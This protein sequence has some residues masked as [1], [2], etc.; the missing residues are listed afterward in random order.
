MYDWQCV[1]IMS[2]TIY[3]KSLAAGVNLQPPEVRRR[4]MDRAI[5]ESVELYDM[6]RGLD[7]RWPATLRET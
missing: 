1:A 7:L 4:I 6:Q 2:A 5:Q 3:A